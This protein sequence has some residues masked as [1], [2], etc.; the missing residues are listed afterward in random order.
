MNNRTMHTV[1]GLLVAGVLCAGCAST[2]ETDATRVE[3]DFGN[4]VRQMVKGQIYDPKAAAKPSAE[5]P[6]GMDGVQGEA[7]LKTHREHVGNPNAVQEDLR[8]GIDQ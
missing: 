4:S 8:L 2:A 1:L 5:P 7:V 3:N 6:M